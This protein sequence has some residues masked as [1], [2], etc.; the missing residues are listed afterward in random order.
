VIELTVHGDPAACRAAAEDARAA[1]RTIEGSLDTLHHAQSSSTSAWEGAAGDGFRSRLTDTAG[2]L[3]ELK[4]RIAPASQA[5]DTFADELDVVK[6]ALA[7]VRAAATAAGLSVSGDTITPP[8]TPEAEADQG[9]VD[10]YNVKVKVY[11][12]AF[13]Q[14]E[15]ART[16]ETKAHTSLGSAMTASNGDGW[17][18]NLME[19]LG[20]APPDGMD[21]VDDTAWLLGLGGLGF[22]VASGTMLKGVLQVFQPRTAVGFG[23]TEGMNYWQR[24]AA[25]TKSDSWRA[26]AYQAATRDKWASAGKWAT[27]AGSVVTAATSGWDQWKA[28]ADDPSLDTGE[29]VDRA[30][31]K[32]AS[33]AAGAYVGAEAGAW[34]GGAIGTAICP[35]IG[36]VIGGAAGGLIGGFAG[37]SAGAWVGDELNNAYDGIG[38]AAADVADKAGDVASD[39]GDAVTFWN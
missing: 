17:F 26:K 4:G 8:S 16:K 22:G 20:F 19:E 34:A 28:D 15:A 9:E 18:E 30:A 32:G 38:H 13:E 21:P 36:T 3:S 6:N 23:S 14:A 25:A 2:D 1:A 12:H 11:N 31:T 33:T 7:D 35:G 29:R 27:R 24:L 37:S 10:A 39:V 5:L